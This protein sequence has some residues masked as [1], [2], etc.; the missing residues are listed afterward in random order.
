MTLC[1]CIIIYNYTYIYI[2][3]YLYIYISIY[4]PYVQTIPY[5]IF[6][7]GRRGCPTWA[8]PWP[9][10]QRGPTEITSMAHFIGKA[11]VSLMYMYLCL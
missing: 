1:I 5:Q 3:I 6:G 9:V 2:Y 7:I 11:H 8:S 4:G 10:M